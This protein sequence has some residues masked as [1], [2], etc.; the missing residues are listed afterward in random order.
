MKYRLNC[1]KK[2]KEMLCTVRIGSLQ[3]RVQLGREG[4]G[5]QGVKE[6]SF[7]VLLNFIMRDNRM[8]LV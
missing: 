8:R 5:F 1:F 2:E 7:G 6:K 3:W 4:R